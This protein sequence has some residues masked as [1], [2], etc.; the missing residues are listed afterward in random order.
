MHYNFIQI[1]VFG[2]FGLR[3]KNYL[4]L[5]NGENLI[6]IIENLAHSGAKYSFAV[7]I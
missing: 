6:N 4:L 2:I 7:K 3:L 5:Q 1:T